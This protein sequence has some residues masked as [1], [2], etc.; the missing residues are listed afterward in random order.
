V[1]EYRGKR[2]LDLAVVAL[3]AP[4]WAPAL[5]LLALLV[6]ARLGAPVFFRQT[7]PGRDGA[8][9]TLVKLR[10]MTDA[11]HPDGSPLPDAERLTPFGRWLRETSLD[12]LPELLNVLRGEMSLVGPR[13]LL[14]QYL[15]RYSPRHRVR[16]AVRPG[17]TG[18]AQV[19]GRNALRWSDKFDLDVEYV[20][21]CSPAL[22]AWILWRTARSVLRREGI[23]AAG[24]ATMPEFTGYD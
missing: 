15:E 2:W 7:R 10:T 14:Q 1:A 21:R 3:A 12:E 9:F 5:G 22:D 20:E 6:R 13:P 18:L 16:H 23:S 17:I 24:D 4:L 8:P 19:S 11:R